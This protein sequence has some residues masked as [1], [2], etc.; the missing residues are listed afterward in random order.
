MESSSSSEQDAVSKKM[1]NLN[2][3]F[4]S[5][6]IGSLEVTV[7]RKGCID[8]NLSGNISLLITLEP[9]PKPCNGKDV[10]S[11]SNDGSQVVDPS[12]VSSAGVGESQN[13]EKNVKMEVQEEMKEGMK[14][15]MKMDVDD[16]GY[17]EDLKE[18]HI[19]GIKWIQDLFSRSLMKAQLLL[20]E[21]WSSSK[22]AEIE[23]EKIENAAA[24]VIAA[25]AAATV[26][27]A[28]ELKV[29]S[30]VNTKIPS[31]PH[32]QPTLPNSTKLINSKI[33]SKVHHTDIYTDSLSGI[34]ILKR[35]INPVLRSKVRDVGD[36]IAMS[37]NRATGGWVGVKTD[38]QINV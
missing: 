38:R 9:I 12:C 23:K 5:E 33:E 10:C 19:S 29:K 11:V 24:A 26:R 16:M 28:S 25:A 37:L 30:A 34:N 20:L 18:S 2:A 4:D 27:S 3:L 7:V 15:G 35:L 21:H 31:T 17:S 36:G 8:I 13:E 1:N 22:L 6:L 14:E 32:T